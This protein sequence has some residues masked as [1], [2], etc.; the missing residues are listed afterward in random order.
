MAPRV[1]EPCLVHIDFGQQT[2]ARLV[3]SLGLERLVRRTLREVRLSGKDHM[4]ALCE[5][6][7]RTETRPYH[8]TTEV[9]RL[10]THCVLVV[11]PP[12][13]A[14]KRATNTHIIFV[15]TVW[16]RAEVLD[17]RKLQSLFQRSE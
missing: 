1:V 15:E 17:S 3:A 5:Q 6:I 2:R 12:P 14:L 4:T 16:F 10:A 7:R 9:P 11:T 13:L 8:V